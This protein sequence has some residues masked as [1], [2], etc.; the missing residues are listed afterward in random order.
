M[1][2]TIA[3]TSFIILSAYKYH[4]VRVR[5]CFNRNGVH[6]PTVEKSQTEYA[7]KY[8]HANGASNG[9]A[10]HYTNATKWNLCPGTPLD[11]K[12]VAEGSGPIDH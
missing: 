3:N 10:E 2:S 4:I 11:Q 6:Q 9:E 12:R 8:V 7:V 5:I 1:C